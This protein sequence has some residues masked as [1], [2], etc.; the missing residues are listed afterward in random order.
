MAAS[1]LSFADP[2]PSAPLAYTMGDIVGVLWRNAGLIGASFALMS[3]AGVGLYYMQVPTYASTARVLVQT[4]QIGAPSF[5]SGIAAYRE[6]LIAEPPTRKLET[7]MALILNRQNAS[8]VVDALALEPSQ[9]ASTPI[10]RIRTAVAGAVR[11]WLGLPRPKGAA[12]HDELVDSFLKSL[13]VEPVRSATAETTSNVLEIGIETTDPALSAQALQGMLDGYLKF[14]A[15]QSHRAGNA[16]TEVVQEQV[17][18]AQQ[19]LRRVEDAVVALAIKESDRATLAASVTAAAG[20][21]GARGAAAGNTVDTA[22]S[23]MANQVVELQ[24]QLDD[25]QQTYTDETQSVRKVKQRLTEARSRLAAYVRSNARQ[26][27]EF[28]RLDRQ[29][30]LAQERYAELRRKL[31][32]IKLYT[33]LTPTGHE[34]RIVVVPPS[35]P[36]PAKGR[37]KPIFALAG[38]IAGLLL[39]LLLAA[40]REFAFPRLRGRRDVERWLGVPL[41][42]VLPPIEPGNAQATDAAKKKVLP[43]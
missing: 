32:Q 16:T 21:T 42:G 15:Q 27:A 18:Q 6:P 43:A 33:E 3:A 39:G 41:L 30:A 2:E 5:L 24:A 22:A 12:R 31:D 36:D 4:D 26:T 38:P 17:R 34:G 37:R 9:L 19:E 29:R 10:A 11:Q 23:Q 1:S 25:L 14:G 40:L 13:A 35:E 28:S 7:E 20:G 8:D